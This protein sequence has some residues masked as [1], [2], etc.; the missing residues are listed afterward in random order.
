MV[1]APLPA[2][3]AGMGAPGVLSADFDDALIQ[4]SKQRS[5][6]LYRLDP[7]RNE[8][9]RVLPAGALR[10]HRQ[11][12]EPLLEVARSGTESLFMQIRDAGYVVLLTD[13]HG[14]AV[15]FINNPVIDRELRQ[16][17]LYLGSCWSEDKEGT[18]AVGL[19]ATER[20]P[21]TVH[22][23]E[24]FR[25]L[26]HALTCSAAPILSPGGELLAV[27]DASALQSPGDKRSQQLVLQMVRFTARMVENANFLRRYENHLVLRIGSRR[28]FLEVTTEGLVALD[29][30][31]HIV[32]ANQRFLQDVGAT[33]ASFAGQHVENVFGV[34][35][36]VLAMAAH[37]GGD[38]IA[39]RLLH[40][41][42]QCFALVRGPRR[43][44]RQILG[45]ASERERPGPAA[46]ATA[47]EGLAG[48]DTRMVANVRQA[49]RVLDKG[50]PVLLNGESGTGKEAFAKAMHEASAR[51][52]RAFV[53]LNCAAIPE[54]L[55]ESEL[56]GYKNGAF[57]GARAKGARGKVLQADGGTL[58]L[59][60]IG[61]MPL[62]MQTRLLRVLAEREVMPLGAEEAT[63]V[64]LQ[65]ICA[66]HRALEDLV[67]S[68]QF[69]LDLYY[70][71]AGLTLTLPALRDRLDK[72]ALIRSV[73]GAEARDLGMDAVPRLADG[74]LA[75]LAGHA[76]PGNIRQLKNVLRAALALSGGET[77]GLEHLP[78]EIA[79][80]F[81]GV[82]PPPRLSSL[83]FNDR[84]PADLLPGM[85]MNG[86]M[87]APAAPAD[88]GE[89][90]LQA[91]R[92][93]QWNVTEAA[94]SLG[95][96]RATVYR[97]MQ[98]Y[99]IVSPNRR[100]SVA[101]PKHPQ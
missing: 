63:P 85:P 24:H 87:S 25:S 47:L 76:W 39:L 80:A 5:I 72:D 12:M 22:H 32:A 81:P 21:I 62:A 67:A 69:R 26:N 54:T 75:R 38:P 59:D 56:F 44:P 78:A 36:D 35:F 42:S 57:T 43:V 15:D 68:G 4:R 86:S 97:W 1:H 88:P 55:I 18:C 23:G 8:A 37:A 96:C 74:V 71:L 45:L 66:T 91:L 50:L 30:G 11:P 29:E 52:G 101:M 89:A 93:H 2:G 79:G 40:S 70:R 46:S 3:M 14:V 82:L 48:G 7:G 73:L 83:G 84:A 51:A 98:K 19:A 95:T 17:G 31:G 13:A 90:L 65:I 53:A 61:D 64:D 49:L 10:E 92:Q 99:G 34:R 100:E 33:P 20:R 94:R 58:F 16:A 77:I 41:G 6:D 60:E 28:E 9:P 27:L